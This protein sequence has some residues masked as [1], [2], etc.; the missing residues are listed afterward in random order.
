MDMLIVNSKLARK[1]PH[2]YELERLSKKDKIDIIALL[3][4][5]IANAE[6]ANAPKDKTQ[7]MIERCC[8]SWVGEQ[9]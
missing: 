2:W 7:E 9:E 6:N 3:S 1:V 4:T 8:G 5:S